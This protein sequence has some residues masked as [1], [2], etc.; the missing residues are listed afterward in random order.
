MLL[1]VLNSF[2]DMEY[3]ERKEGVEPDFTPGSTKIYLENESAT[4][5]NIER[6]RNFPTLIEVIINDYNEPTIDLAPLKSCISIETLQIEAPEIEHLDLTPIGALLNLTRLT[7]FWIPK[8]KELDLSPLAQCTSLESIRIIN[9]TAN[10][11]D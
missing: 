9:S 7:L 6:L 5:A 1:G 2:F 11:L 3:I 10:E 4:S 8:V